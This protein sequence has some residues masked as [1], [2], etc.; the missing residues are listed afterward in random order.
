[1][2]TVRTKISDITTEMVECDRE[3][4]MKI[5]EACNNYKKDIRVLWR[6]LKQPGEPEQLPSGLTLLE[7]LK[8]LK[9]QLSRLEEKR[10]QIM[11]Q[12]RSLIEEE[13]AL[14]SKLGLEA[15]YIDED[16]IPEKD[17]M[18]RV[19]DNLRKMIRVK[20]ERET[21]MFTMKE[22]IVALLDR[23]GMD[24]NATTLSSV[25]DGDDEYDS[26]KSS[27][28]RS[29]QH[30]MEELKTTLDQ[31]RDEVEALMSD[32]S[33]LYSRLSIP[34]TEQCP[35]STGQ[36]CGVE[37]LIRDDNL[38]QLRQEKLK[39]EV[40]KNENL[41]IIVD[42]AKSELTELWKLCMVGQKEQ[43]L[44]LSGLV[45]DT[46]ETLGDV[47][48]EI[49]RLGRYHAMHKDTL[50]KMAMFIDLCDLAPSGS[51]SMTIRWLRVQTLPRSWATFTFTREY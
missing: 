45:E 46:D 12:F 23:L 22:Q 41:K 51:S 25:L 10:N 1:M 27:D 14:A 44:F 3:N 39:L 42:N 28:L 9:L 13:R 31:K 21:H 16:T 18:Q 2:N 38:N 6:K 7:Q 35:L 5:E 30:T 48:T 11:G 24:L 33:N 43:E 8:A 20:E 50:Q 29:V 36:V 32:I 15:V 37:E 4:K 26:L 34:A 19:E 47:E 17:E 40:M 49:S